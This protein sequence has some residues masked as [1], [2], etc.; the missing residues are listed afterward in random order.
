MSATGS[1]P[2][3]RHAG[4]TEAPAVEATGE[5]NVSTDERYMHRS[6]AFGD[7]AAEAEGVSLDICVIFSLKFWSR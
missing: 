5:R 3:D 2:R 6:R 7:L 4:E 1:L